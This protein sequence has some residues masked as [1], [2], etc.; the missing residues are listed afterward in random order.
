MKNANG[1]LSASEY[2]T[3]GSLAAN[4]PTH[5]SVYT[6]QAGHRVVNQ[7]FISQNQMQPLFGRPGTVSQYS[8]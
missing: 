7:R 5:P 6:A 1:F 8:L 4:M 3:K 2:F